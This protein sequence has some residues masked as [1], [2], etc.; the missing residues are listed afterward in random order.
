MTKL[1]GA[2]TPKKRSLTDNDEWGSPIHIVQAA[3]G[4]MGSIDCDPATTEL[5]NKLI[6]KAPVYYTKNNNG[7]KHRW[8][9]NVW[10]NPPISSKFDF[11][12][13]ANYYYQQQ[14]IN[15]CFLL[16]PLNTLA[17]HSASCLDKY[18]VCICR[19]RMRFN[20][21]DE[22]WNDTKN[23]GCNVF[24]YMGE[25]IEDFESIFKIYGRII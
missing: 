13:L 25:Y 14:I 11:I 24:A 5:Y 3:R 4:L 15:Q 8:N 22:N 2:N 20:T 17:C 10:L 9:G 21:V 7:L 16:L 23:P 1:L 12:K 6:I 19:G 18:P